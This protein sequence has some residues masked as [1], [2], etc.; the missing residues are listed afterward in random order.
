MA[1]AKSQHKVYA[2]EGRVPGIGTVKTQKT[3]EFK[4]GGFVS[5]NDEA[6]KRCGAPMHY[7]KTVKVP[8]RQP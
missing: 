3:R 1:G 5:T 2:E 6:H 8:T 7:G 4:D